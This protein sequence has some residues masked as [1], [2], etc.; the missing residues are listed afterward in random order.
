[1]LEHLPY[2]QA[3]KAFEE[4]IRVASKNI[5]IS[6]PDSQPRWVYSF[7]IPKVGQKVIHLPRPRKKTPVHEFNGEHY[8]EINKKGYPLQKV[9]D[10]FSKQ[11]ISL[12]NTY[13]VPEYPYHRFFIFDKICD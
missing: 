13:R 1:M 4:M 9:L 3:L 6:L 10:D 2:E 7:H 5:V 12:L 8:W 11:N